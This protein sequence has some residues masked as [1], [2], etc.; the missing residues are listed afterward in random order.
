LALTRRLLFLSFHFGADAD[1]GADAHGGA[2]IGP[3]NAQRMT[4]SAAG[5]ADSTHYPARFVD[6]I[7]RAL[8]AAL[9][10]IDDDA[11]ALGPS[12]LADDVRDRGLHALSYGLRL[13][14]AWPEV[15]DLMLKLARPLEGQGYR[16]DWMEL[17][18]RGIEIAQANGDVRACIQLRLN[19]GRLQ[20]LL[21]QYEKSEQSL[22]HSLTLAEC[23]GDTPLLVDVR[24]RLAELA[25]HRCR[26][27]EA[28]R[29]AE[30]T[31]AM[32]PAADPLCTSSY[33][34]L[35]HVTLRGGDLQGAA[36]YYLTALNL[37]IAQQGEELT[38]A[39]I[40]RDIGTAYIFMS[41]MDEALALLGRSQQ[42][43][44]ERG[45]QLEIAILQMVYGI[46]HWRR[47]EYDEAV[48]CYDRAAPAFLTCGNLA[49]LA[50]NNNN[51]G[52][53]LQA[54]GEHARAEA[55][56]RMS[57]E[58]ARTVGDAFEAANAL[59]TL[60]VFCVQHGRL[61]EAR[62][63]W[64]DALSTIRQLPEPPHSLLQSILHRLAA[65]GI[66]E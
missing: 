42:I 28:R 30:G 38:I 2:S 18:A 26:V 41:R 45:D 36:T 21:G 40:L 12:R 66:A 35:G 16:R 7:V 60:A 25:L 4:P 32:F 24:N 5:G 3:S 55:V 14:E 59:D 53:L 31:L 9:A 43:A 50:R 11:T 20:T 19:V 34:T 56:I 1:G 48:A 54:M 46:Y 44:I 22:G 13:P 37:A 47:S 65:L 49:W 33:R 39:Q 63:T 62:I 64:A 51:R 57:I 15:R 10:A 29:I 27:G 23:A 8:R 52:L 58:Q 17:L 6:N 61:D